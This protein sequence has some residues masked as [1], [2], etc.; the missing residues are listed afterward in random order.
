[1]KEDE[2]GGACGTYLKRLLGVRREDDIKMDL[3]K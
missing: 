3:E 1:V 2:I